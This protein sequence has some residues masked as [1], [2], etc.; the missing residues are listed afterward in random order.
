[1]KSYIIVLKYSHVFYP[2]R[3]LRECNLQVDMI[4]NGRIGYLTAGSEGRLLIKGARPLA[5]K[6]LVVP[7]A[8]RS[9]SMTN[10]NML[11]FVCLSYS[12][13]PMTI[14]YYIS[15]SDILLE[16]SDS[17]MFW[18]IRN[19]IWML[20]LKV[21]IYIIKYCC[22]LL[23]GCRKGQCW[24]V[25]L[26]DSGANWLYTQAPD[27]ICHPTATSAWRPGVTISMSLYYYFQMMHWYLRFSKCRHGM[28]L[29]STIVQSS[30]WGALWN[31]ASLLPAQTAA[32]PTNALFLCWEAQPNY[33]FVC[34]D[35]PFFSKI[36]LCL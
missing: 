13:I 31:D 3:A 24:P 7:L 22:V 36:Q 10:R 18:N 6:P 2:L 30:L 9:P 8:A 26:G 21:Y 33:R 25:G 11:F 12:G 34:F 29:Q 1:M 32:T 16:M 4:L 17:G 15:P 5:R 19:C 35:T 23:W 27:G 14:Q 20:F 28:L